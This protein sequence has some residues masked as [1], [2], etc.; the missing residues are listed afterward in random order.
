VPG[1]PEIISD[2]SL[3]SYN[4]FGININARYLAVIKSANDLKDILSDPEF[5]DCPLLILGGGSN[6]L[7]TGD[8]EGLVLKNELKGINLVKETDTEVWIDAKSGEIWHDLVK[9]CIKNNYGGIENLSLIPGTVGAAPIQNIGAYGAELK[10]VFYFLTAIDLHDFSVKIFN[11]DDCRFG[12]R[13]SIFKR[14]AKGRYFINTVMLK[15]QKHPVLNT[16]Y[17][18]IQK[19]LETKGITH[20]GIADVSEAV[21]EIRTSKLPNPAVIGNA[22]S[23]FKNP[24]I[25]NEQY[26]KLKELYPQ[27]PGYATPT[28][29]KVPA[30]W[31]IES[32]GWKGKRVGETGSHKDQAL[33][34]VNYGQAR[35]EEVKELALEIQKSVKDKFGIVITPEVNIL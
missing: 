2:I 3:K 5:K 24:E 13:D 27:M 17:G 6:I 23:F 7:F 19:I 18:A 16:S 33:V 35:G 28:G 12:Y 1:L 25:P 8:F 34:L 10:D 29:M 31:L 15:L 30:G 21:C 32:C 14:E 4:T 22:G 20:P 26:Q 11:L 9:Y